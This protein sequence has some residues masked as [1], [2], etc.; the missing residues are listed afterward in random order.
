MPIDLPILCRHLEPHNTVL[1]FGAGSSIPSG[2]LSGTE[3]AQRIA[4]EF[5]IDYDP[6]LR[7]SDVATIVERRVDRRNLIAFL[8]TLIEPLSPTGSILN[9]P[10]FPWKSIYTTNY[11]TL[12]ERAY[13]RARRD[14]V[15]YKSNFDFSIRGREATPRLFKLD[16]SIE[17]DVTDGKTSR[18]VI[19]NRDYEVTTEY[20]ENLYDSLKLAAVT[21]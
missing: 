19:S 3:I 9:I 15:V 4:R 21:S 12:I 17:D 16:G 10:L 13:Q 6:D 11:D 7:L 8:R 14:L 5:E 18:I 1:L 20:R 2:G